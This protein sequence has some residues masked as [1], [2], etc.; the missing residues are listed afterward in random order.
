MKF[1]KYYYTQLN[2][3]QRKDIENFRNQ[4]LVGNPK[5]FNGTP[6]EQKLR[7]TMADMYV[8]VVENGWLPPHM[9]EKDD[10]AASPKDNRA[11]S[12]PQTTC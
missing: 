3:K 7:E 1:D 6:E 4:E 8:A 11:A 12:P 9:R 2:D 5:F 10:R